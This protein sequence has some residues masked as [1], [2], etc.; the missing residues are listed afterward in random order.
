LTFNPKTNQSPAW[1]PDGRQIAFSSD[2]SGSSQIYRKDSAGAGQEERLTN[3]P[4]LKYVNDW[5][6]DGRYLLY[7]QADVA[8][9][10]DFLALP[11]EGDRK[12]VTVFSSPSTQADGRFS[13]NGKWIAYQS[14][15]S[16][17]N[18]VYVQTFPGAP[19]APKGKWQVSV[20]GGTS[21]VWRGDG[22][23]LFFLAG[24]KMMAAGVRETAS[25]LEIDT[26]RELFSTTATPNPYTPYDV[27]ADGQRFLVQEPAAGGNDNPLTVIVNWQAGLKQ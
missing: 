10:F 19:S 26:P 8:R 25:G 17:K 4:Q 23:E 12:P 7:M 2:R 9:S 20:R 13:P 5:S 22:K 3:T 16:G 11:L 15:E 6:R 27:T 18:E 1:S 14:D 21:P 24:N